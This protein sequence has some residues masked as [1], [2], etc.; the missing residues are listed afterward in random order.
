[1]KFADKPNEELGAILRK[2]HEIQ[3]RISRAPKHM[4][5]YSDIQQRQ[6][7]TPLLAPDPAGETHWN[8][9]IDETTR[10]N[11]IM[12]NLREA[13]NVLLVPNGD[14]FSMAKES[15]RESNDLS[16]LT[17]NLE[18]NMILRQFEGAAAPAKYLCLFL[19]DKK[20]TWSYVLFTI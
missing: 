10:A 17:Y 6:S 13:N 15:K 2:S 11:Q 7:C 12:G 16:C 20:Y 8:G 14:D 3:V 9:C 5:L 19:Q 18:D 1:M 4:K